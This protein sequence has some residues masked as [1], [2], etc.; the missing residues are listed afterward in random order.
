MAPLILIGAALG[1]AAM[2]FF[3]PQQGRRRRAL[4]RDKVVKAETC[5]RD[6]VDAGTRD[7]ASRGSAIRGRIGSRFTKKSATDDV[8]AERVRSK[9]G[10]YVAHPGAIE[11]SVAAGRATLSGAVLAHEHVELLEAVRSV[12]GIEDVSDQLGVYE[13]AAGISELQSTGRQRDGTGVPRTWAPGTQLIAGSALT[14]FLLRHSKRA[15]ALLLIAAGAAALM[16]LTPSEQLQHLA[17]GRGD[18]SDRM[19]RNEQTESRAEEVF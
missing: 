15:R 12:P 4:V 8:I 13:T 2:F 7:L 17:S 6:F 1:S 19:P 9:M 14:L 5:V 3:D 10:R 16:R 11:V 18:E